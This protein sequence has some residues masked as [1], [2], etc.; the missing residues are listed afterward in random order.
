MCAHISRSVCVRW[1]QAALLCYINCKPHFLTKRSHWLKIGWDESLNLCL[2]HTHT[3]KHTCKHTS[4]IQMTPPPTHPP[5]LTPTTDSHHPLPQPTC[6]GVSGD[7][8]APAEKWLAFWGRTSGMYKCARAFKCI[9][10]LVAVTSV[11]KE[12]RHVE[13]CG[14]K[15]KCKKVNKWTRNR[16]EVKKEVTGNK[17]GERR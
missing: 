16:E 4:V 9:T 10:D 2:T 12:L 13:M 15:K 8:S 11:V 17:R 5:T 1:S 6:V 7:F 14:N 3:C